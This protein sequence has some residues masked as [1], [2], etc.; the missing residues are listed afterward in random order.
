MRIRKMLKKYVGCSMGYEL[1]NNQKRCHFGP[2]SLISLLCR[3]LIE[4]QAIANEFNFFVNV[5]KEM[6]KKCSVLIKL[7]LLIF[8]IPPV[9]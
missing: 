5:G 9:I 1:I 2:T 6:A 4:L 7:K 8:L 3:T